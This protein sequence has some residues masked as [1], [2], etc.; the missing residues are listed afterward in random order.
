MIDS[1]CHLNFES[2]SK[3]IDLIVNNSKKNNIKSLLSIN[4]N[5]N[6]FEKHLN[7]VKNYKGIYLSYGLHPCEVQNYKITNLDFNNYCN[8]SQVV[9]IGET[10]IDLF[11]SNN[12]L[13]NQILSFEK[14]IE[15]SIKYKLPLIIHQRNS[16]NEIIN[17]LENYICEDL[18]VVFHCFTGSNKLLNFCLKNKFYISLAGIVTFKN[19][20]NLRET[21]KNY[22]LNLILIETDSPFLAPVPMRGKTNEPSFVKYI[23]EYLSDFYNIDFYEFEKITDNNFFN[24]FNKTKRDNL[25]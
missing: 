13:K 6:D 23:A 12:F 22:P 19:A 8:Y 16:E 10:G 24:L 15:A 18:K 9:G 25:L 21:I 4:T 11:H 2:M 5:P 3:N 20:E 17:I 1:H 7:L 14:H